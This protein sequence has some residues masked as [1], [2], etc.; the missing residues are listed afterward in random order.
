MG[1]PQV[2]PNTLPDIDVCHAAGWVVASVAYE[3]LALAHIINAEGEKIQ[4]VLGTLQ[5]PNGGG[6]ANP[7]PPPPATLSDILAINA[8]VRETLETVICKEIVLNLKLCQAFHFL[9]KHCPPDPASGSAPVVA[10]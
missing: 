1:M 4:F 2:P 9:E 5:P 7:M 6:S 10:P 3:E 8:S